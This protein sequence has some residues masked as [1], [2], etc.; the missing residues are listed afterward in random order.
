MEFSEDWRI[1]AGMGCNKSL[2]RKCIFYIIV[3]LVSFVLAGIADSKTAQASSA[4]V[5]VNSENT[6]VVK[7]DVV[8]VV[9]TVSSADEI[10]GFKGYFSYDNS[11][12]KYVTGGNVTSD[13]KAARYKK[14]YFL[15]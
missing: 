7:G 13:V 15:K 12:L 1:L 14:Q 6:S 5:S 8:Y 9:I 3:V 10:G 4:S 2:N 11:V